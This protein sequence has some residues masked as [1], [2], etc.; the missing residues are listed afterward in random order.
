MIVVALNGAARRPG[1]ELPQ[2]SELKSCPFCGKQVAL[3]D[4]C[5]ELEDCENFER[6]EA[7]GYYAVVCDVNEGGCGASG[8]YARTEQEAV[9]AWNRRAQPDHVGAA[10]EM[11]PLESKN[12]GE[13]DA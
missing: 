12:G 7:T 2:M 3:I 11:M 4:N 13:Q 6:C 8:G 5:H 1:K 10:T 9:A